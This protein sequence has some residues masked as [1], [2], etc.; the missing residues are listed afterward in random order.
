[1]EKSLDSKEQSAIGRP[2]LYDFEGILGRADFEIARLKKIEQAKDKSLFRYEEYNSRV[3][4]ETSGYEDNYWLSPEITGTIDEW[5]KAY[6]RFCNKK[7]N[8][9]GKKVD[10]TKLLNDKFATNKFSKKCQD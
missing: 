10:R 9:Y 4:E 3:R 7:V 1:M 8:I 5:T 6:K 2:I